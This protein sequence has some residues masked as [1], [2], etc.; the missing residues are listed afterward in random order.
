[1]QIPSGFLD[2]V[3]TALGNPLSTKY[4]FRLRHQREQAQYG[5]CLFEIVTVFSQNRRSINKN[6][7]A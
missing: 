7:T 6:M 1:M 2:D 4:I 3:E 5:C